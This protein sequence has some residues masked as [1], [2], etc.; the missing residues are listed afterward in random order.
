MSLRRAVREL[1]GALPP[2][3]RVSRAI[4]GTSPGDLGRAVR[5]SRDVT[6]ELAS[7]PQA[8]ADSVTNFSRLTGVLA[9]ESRGV[10]A[11]VAPL[12]VS[13]RLLR[14]ACVRWTARCRR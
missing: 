14:R 9:D 4:Q 2:A 3:T 12:T 10:A 7:D 13:C 8:L 5:A 6:G 1:G 11:S